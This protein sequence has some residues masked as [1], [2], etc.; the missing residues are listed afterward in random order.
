MNRFFSF[1]NLHVR[2]VMERG[3]HDVSFP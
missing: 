1:F 2:G 3:V